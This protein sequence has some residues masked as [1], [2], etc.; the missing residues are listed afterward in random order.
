MHKVKNILL[1]GVGGQG[2]LLASRIISTVAMRAGLD[3]K[4][5]D[6]HGMA[7]R[8]GSVTS[9]IRIG[10]HVFSPIIPEGAVDFLVALEK[11]EALRYAHFIRDN[12]KVLVN[13]QV[14]TPVSVS[15]GASTYPPDIDEQIAQKFSNL[16]TLDCIDI[17]KRLGNT[18]VSNTLLLGA[19]SSWLPFDEEQWLSVIRDLVKDR[20][21]DINIQAFQHGKEM[22]NL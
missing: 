19:L 14:I 9:Q 20:F 1:T 10:E 3:V 13:S 17:A 12:A 18:R 21:V 11:L 8:G 2:I 6:V 5:A 16:Y 7:Q 15:M 22:V 4:S